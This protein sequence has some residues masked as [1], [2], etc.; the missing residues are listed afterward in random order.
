MYQKRKNDEK[1]R[2]VNQNK[3]LKMKLRIQT[4]V[5]NL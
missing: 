1:K 5:P 3:K 2:S 4:H